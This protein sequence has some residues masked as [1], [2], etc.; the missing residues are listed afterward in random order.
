MNKNTDLKIKKI[1]ENTFYV[2][3]ENGLVHKKTGRAEWSWGSFK[4]IKDAKKEIKRL[5]K[6]AVWILLKQNYT[7]SLYFA[8]R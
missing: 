1:D 2:F 4:S 3:S 5:L 6:V 7:E 8:R